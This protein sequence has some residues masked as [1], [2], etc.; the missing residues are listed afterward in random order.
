[1]MSIFVVLKMEWNGIE[2]AVLGEI[3]RRMVVRK[4]ELIEFLHGKVD[5][6][7]AFVDAIT[8]RLYN[9]DMITYV[10]PLGKDCFA[11]TLKG[12][13]LNRG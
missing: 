2:R 10:T 8:K 1:M 12:L 4:S 7:A 3:S 13:Q 5:N 9:Q 11:V 6:P